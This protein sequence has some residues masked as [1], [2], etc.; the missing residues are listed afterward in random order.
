MHT[1]RVAQLVEHAPCKREVA[2]SIPAAGFNPKTHGERSERQVVAALLAAGYDVL[3]A[4]IGENR[5]YDCVI[6][7]GDRFVRVQ[8][9]TARLSPDGGARIAAT[10]N[11]TGHGVARRRLSYHGQA[12]VF[13]LY[14]PDTGKVY[15][16]PVAEAPGTTIYLR[17][18][19]PKNRQAAGVRYAADYEMRPVDSHV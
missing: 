7:M 11:C 18:T 5:R 6:D 4:A 1:A 15:V 19:P 16:V 9:K 2:G 13:A 14:S 3:V 17:L 12:D 10:A 8:A